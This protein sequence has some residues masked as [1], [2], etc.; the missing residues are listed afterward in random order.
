MHAK[1]CLSE[2]IILKSTTWGQ[3]KIRFVCV[4]DGRQVYPSQW[5]PWKGWTPPPS[6]TSSQS[7][8]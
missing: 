2:L 8:L 1:P 3:L 6:S 7:A 5:L 4:W